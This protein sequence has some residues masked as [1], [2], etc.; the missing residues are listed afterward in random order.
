MNERKN[1]QVYCHG[2]CYNYI[3]T[4]TAYY[5]HQHISILLQIEARRTCLRII[6]R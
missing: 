5:N 3:E 2:A 4:K 6:V 1:H